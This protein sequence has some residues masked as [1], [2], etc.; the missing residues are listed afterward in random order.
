MALTTRPRSHAERDQVIAAILAYLAGLTA[1]PALV[2]MDLRYFA[3]ARANYIAAR[4]D[5]QDKVAAARLASDAADEADEVFDRKVKRLVASV[6]DEEGRPAP[7]VLA[8]MMGGLLPSELTVLPY[9]TE[10]QKAGDLLRQLRVRT[11]LG[12]DTARLDALEA[13]IAALEA[14][15]TADEEAGRAARV[16]GSALTEARDEFD[17]A[18]GKLVRAWLALAGE[19]AT[20]AVLPRF[21]RREATAAAAAE[22][23]ELT[24]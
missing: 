11:D 3:A 14:A 6:L 1:D 19:E 10:V 23:E 4:A 5:Y 18:Y 8:D 22:A 21:T 17:R 12:I 15:T 24:P 7:R 9:R 2:A 20:Y 16:A 13:A